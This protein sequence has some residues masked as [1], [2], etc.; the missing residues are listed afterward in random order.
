MTVTIKTEIEN[1]FNIGDKVLVGARMV[2]TDEVVGISVDIIDE[3]LMYRLRD[4]G[5]IRAS[6][7][8]S[9]EQGA[10]LL[11]SK[12]EEL[13]KQAT[14]YESY[15]VPLNA[16]DEVLVVKK[17]EQEVGWSDTWEE[18][19]D[20]LV[21]TKGKVILSRSTGISVATEYDGSSWSFPRS[22]LKKI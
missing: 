15:S 7:V 19:M 17:V 2:T 11:R 22:A 9:L 3:S 13:I 1:D 21:G 16:G 6:E 5:W 12:A 20:V 14:G 10:R 4:Y 18:G 8:I